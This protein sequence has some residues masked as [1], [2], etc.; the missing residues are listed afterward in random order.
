MAEA[1][2]SKKRGGHAYGRRVKQL[3]NTAEEGELCLYTGHSL[4][5][6]STHSMRYDSHQACV[7]CV[8]SARE[9]RMSFDISKL[10]KKN[11][12]KALKFWSQVDI[13]S[14]D[15][16]WNWQ[17]CVNSRTKQ[18]QFA[19]RRHGISSSTQH[20]P[21]RVAMWF[22]WG[23]LGFTGVKTT[24]GNKYCCN[25]FHLIPQN[26]GVF[27]DHDSYLESFELACELHTLKQQIAEYMIEQAVKEQEKIEAEHDIS[28]REELLLDPG[29]QF[30]ERFE[31]VMV[32]ILKGRHASQIH[33][34]MPG[35]FEHP[36]QHETDDEDPTSDF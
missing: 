35:L 5:R 4:G 16:C 28:G 26:V 30:D 25:P 33:P 12:V 15:E 24:C 23:D 34:N 9:G 7:R 31:A 3:S 1:Q 36:E 13:S 2:P 19:W 17:G 29:T 32:D 14:P 27:V 22:T 18:P 11:R 6:F 8:A 10:L 21:Q 20:H